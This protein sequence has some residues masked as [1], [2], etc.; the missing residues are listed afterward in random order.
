[1]RPSA[2]LAAQEQQRRFVR[3]MILAGTGPVDG[4]SI[5]AVAG[6]ANV[7]L[8]RGLFTGQD[9]KQYL[10]FTHTPNGIQAGKAFPGA[11]EGA[12]AGS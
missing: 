4:V 3:K 2:S 7:D 12:F 5:S 10:F 8:P 6:V 1:M 9:P 11:I